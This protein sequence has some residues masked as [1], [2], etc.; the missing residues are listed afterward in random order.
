MLPSELRVLLFDDMLLLL[1]AK[2][3]RFNDWQSVIKFQ[4]ALIVEGFIGGGKGHKFVM[5]SWNTEEEKPALTKEKI[6]ELLLKRK[7]IDAERKK[8]KNGRI[9]D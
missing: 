7:L 1:E 8:L 4:T 9:K 6:R 2:R 3:K 5:S